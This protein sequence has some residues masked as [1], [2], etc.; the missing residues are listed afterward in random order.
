MCLCIDDLFLALVLIPLNILRAA[1]S[2]NCYMLNDRIACFAYD[3]LALLIQISQVWILLYLNID[4]VLMINFP[5]F[6]RNRVS[7]KSTLES[8]LGLLCIE[9]LLFF[10]SLVSQIA[11]YKC[12]ESIPFWLQVCTIS[13]LCIFYVVGVV[14]SIQTSILIMKHSVNWQNV[15]VVNVLA[16]NFIIVFVPSE[17]YWQFASEPSLSLYEN[18]RLVRYLQSVTHGLFIYMVRPVYRNAFNLMCT[19]NPLRWR[20]VIR[21]HEAT[22]RLK[23]KTK[24]ETEITDIAT[25]NFSDV[26]SSESYV[27]SGSS[28]KSPSTVYEDVMSKS[29]Y[30]RNTVDER[31][32]RAFLTDFS[33]AGS[34]V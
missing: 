10:I 27:K 29:S 26:I 32:K 23:S 31:K 21:A 34:S 1:E 12:N 33:D 24:N 2:T 16:I 8:L 18:L 17:I 3:F 5:V 30:G 7:N 22:L 6:Y 20:Q 25:R 19:S 13:F 15:V 14:S 11:D 9:V 28:R 4:K